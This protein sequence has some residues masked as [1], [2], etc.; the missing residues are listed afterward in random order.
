MKHT[1]CRDQCPLA[2]AARNAAVAAMLL[3]ILALAGCQGTPA[4]A[5]AT[6]AAIVAPPPPPEAVPLTALALGQADTATIRGVALTELPVAFDLNPLLAKDKQYRAEH[7]LGLVTNKVEVDASRLHVKD[8]L[9]TV[10]INPFV[11]SS[12][13]TGLVVKYSLQ[14]V[15][16]PGAGAKPLAEAEKTLLSSR[17]AN[18]LTWFILGRNG[19]VQSAFGPDWAL[20]V[21]LAGD[22]G[23][24]CWNVPASGADEV[25]GSYTSGFRRFVLQAAASAHDVGGWRC[26]IPVVGH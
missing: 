8:A 1:A 25:L 21:A 15:N 23:V 7:G 10:A 26:F 11:R 22:K 12:L 19:Q 9:A 14:P 17:G 24:V 13:G 4:P 6:Q 3:S 2:A 20:I 16:N 5:A 18:N